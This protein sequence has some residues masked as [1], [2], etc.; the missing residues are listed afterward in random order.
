M[1]S[2]QEDCAREELMTRNAWPGVVPVWWF[3]WD[4]LTKPGQ[5]V[6]LAFGMR[7]WDSHILVKSCEVCVHNTI[8]R[9]VRIEIGPR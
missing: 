4:L 2:T 8:V 7:M 1:A 5:I 6:I 3:G 9:F